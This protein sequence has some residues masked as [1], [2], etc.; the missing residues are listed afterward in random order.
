MAGS[1]PKALKKLE[2]DIAVV[3]PGYDETKKQ[4]NK[5]TRKEGEFWIEFDGRARKIN[6][7]KDVLPGSEVPIFFLENKK[8]LS[9]VQRKKAALE[10]FAF[11]SKAI[12]EFVHYFPFDLVHLNDWHTALLPFL[13]K[14]PVC[15]EA[16][17]C[18]WRQGG[19]GESSWCQSQ[20]ATVLTLHNF[21]HQGI[22]PLEILLKLG[23]N[24]DFSRVLCWDVSDGNVEMLM[25]GIIHADIVNTVSPAYAQEILDPKLMGRLGEV[26]KGKEG[27][28]KGILNGI[29]D[30]VWNPETDTYINVNYASKGPT[31][32][33]V[34]VGVNSS[35]RSLS[36]VGRTLGW[37]EG[38]RL[39]KLALQKELG[40]PEN[41][42]MPLLGFV[43]RLAKEQKGPE[44]LY[45]ALQKLLPK[46]NFQF[47]LLGTGN[48]EWQAQF[49]NLSKRENVK[50]VIR[51]DE[52]LAHRIYAGADFMIVP[53]KFEP[54][55]LVQMIAMRYGT[56]P[57]VRKTGGL[58]DTVEDGVNG[59]VFKSYSAGALIR[60]VQRALNTFEAQPQR[61]LTSS[62]GL[63]PRVGGASLRGRGSRLKGLIERA[64]SED[65]SWEASAKEYIKLYQ[66]AIAVSGE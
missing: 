51:F 29:D 12:A 21:A 53:S 55:G 61:T 22:A 4:R 18:G 30:D 10:Q 39:N 50:A 52:G 60:C 14:L 26:L 65:F 38:K 36:L 32:P 2:V 3:M 23:V 16:A 56:L 45:G 9:E 42:K 46:K 49:K 43:G 63:R 62:R 58:A 37:Q 8:Y 35:L 44:I 7:W 41:E 24:E 15:R 47:V 28:V 40:L 25:E 31:H 19:E 17:D 13:L 33:D 5:E 11:F 6:I 66:K 59:F 64:M 48:K 27:R 1:L 57:I 34:S 54:C 20:L